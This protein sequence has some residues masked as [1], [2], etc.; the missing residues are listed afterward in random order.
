MQQRNTREVAKEDTQK[1]DPV[2]ARVVDKG[3]V[4]DQLRPPEK[5]VS[6]KEA[7]EMQIQ[8]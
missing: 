3:P 2:A 8:L 5:K 4:V 7:K 1:V 6:S